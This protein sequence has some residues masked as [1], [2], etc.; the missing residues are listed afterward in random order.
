MNDTILEIK[1]L[2]KD[3]PI[4]QGAFRKPKLLH[5]VNHVSLSLARGETLGVVGETG[6]GKSTLA[7][8]IIRLYDPDGGSVIF[9]S[10]RLG[11]EV[12][13]AL[14]DRKQLREVRPTIQYVFQDPYSSLN[15]RMNIRNVLCEPLMVQ[16]R[17]AV[18]EM[19]DRAAFFLEKVGLQPDMLSRYPHE[20]SGGQRQRIVLARSLMLDPELLLCDEPVSALDVASQAK[21]LNLFKDLAK[22]FSLSYLFIAHDLGVVRYISDWVAVMYLGRIV[23]YGTSKHIYENPKHPYTELLLRS[24]PEVGKEILPRKDIN[25]LDKIAVTEGCVFKDRCPYRMDICERNEPE[26][27]H[28]TDGSWALCHRFK[29]LT[30]QGIA[31]G[32]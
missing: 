31:E 4:A 23:E 24:I 7:R 9:K 30:L 14:L 12:D 19:T 28:A 10:H 32:N 6:C 20:F 15:Q 17:V 1:G 26:V 27:Q 13:L 2:C 22:E 21:T 18:S 8:T 16:K 29:E 5:A 25:E 11:K 3:F